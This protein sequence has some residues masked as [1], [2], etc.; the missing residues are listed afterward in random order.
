M[1]RTMTRRF[2]QILLL[3][4]VLVL[5]LAPAQAATF[6]ESL[7]NA[8]DCNW[9]N[10]ADG[11][12]FRVGL[13]KTQITTSLAHEGAG[14]LKFYFDFPQFGSCLQ[15][16]ANFID[17]CGGY[18]DRSIPA[19][20]TLWQRFW[21]YL[22]P[23]F[24]ASDPATKIVK[25][26]SNGYSD[27]LSFTWNN[28]TN[29]VM[30]NQGWPTAGETRIL[31]SSAVV[32]RGQWVCIVVG[33]SLNTPGVANG[34]YTLYMNDVLH[35]NYSDVGWR[36][37]GDNNLINYTRLFTQYGAGTMLMDQYAV[38]DT[39]IDC[40]SNPGGGGGPL[41]DTS[42]PNAPPTNLNVTE[43]WDHFKTLVETVWQWIGPRAAEAATAASDQVV[44]RWEPRL[45][46]QFTLA[47]TGFA[48][49]GAKTFSN[50][51]AGVG[52]LTVLLPNMPPGQPGDDR[53]LCATER[54]GKAQTGCNQLALGPIVLLP[55]PE[56]QPEPE[57]EL[58][59]PAIVTMSGDK[60]FI[61][62]DPARY[63]KAKTTGTGTKR[64]ITCLK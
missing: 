17:N 29:L 3:G 15:G 35:A 62:C 34:T 51:D 56:P 54:D 32:P 44:I 38:G 20:A 23:D 11:T 42:P 8:Q 43:L 5:G 7:F 1:M 4:W 57:P 12:C 39:R 14:S 10:E 45:G 63:T 30:A 24:V 26:G 47:L 64:V 52:T 58:I 25:V 50:I 22:G 46:Q 41:P 37:A 21:M 33:R 19:T 2:T 40:G 55:P 31:G 60:I 61:A 9:T 6:W 36:L 13:G 18:W 27:W 59:G 53:W 16:H 49:T 28:S 48:W